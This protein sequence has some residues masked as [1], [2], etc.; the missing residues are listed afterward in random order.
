[1]ATRYPPA[2]IDAALALHDNRLP[3]AER[4]LKD[5]LKR[6]PFEPRAIRMLAELAGRIGRNRDAETLLRRALE[7]APAFTAARANL[8]IV[9]YRLNRPVE[10]L[11][12]LDALLAAEPDHVGH[13]NLKAAALGRLGSFADAIPLY[14]NVLRQAPNQPKVWMSYGHMLKTVGRQQDGVEAYRRAIALKPELGEAWWSLANLKTVRFDD[15]DVAAM[16]A[17]LDWVGLTDEDR[18][19]LDF[20]LGKA[21]EE[22]RDADR[23][24]EHY[25]RGNALRRTQIVY[26]ADETERFVDDVA[27]VATR[28]FFA[29]RAGWGCP[30]REVIFVLGMPR[31]GSTLI[32]QILASHSQIEGTTE[33]PDLP[34]LARRIADYPAGLATLTAD[35]A[36]AMGE[37]Y[38]RRTA[39]QRRTDRPLFIDKLPNNWAHVALIRLI[40]PNAIVIDARREPRACCFSNYKQHFAR[41]QAFSYSLDDMGRYY[42]DY[43]RAMAHVDAVLPGWAH[44]VIHEALVEDTEAEVRR[45][46]AACGVA[47][48]PACLAF[49]DT[50]RAVRTASSE[51][52]RQPIYR[53]GNDAWVPFASRLGTLETA[54]GAVVGAYPDAPK[55]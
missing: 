35:E 39:V 2:L 17:A 24:F 21:W 13:A 53:T 32:E 26:D 15:G 45:M 3:E 55:A 42:R 11:D 41:G 14:E 46:L 37:D 4:G 28:E 44:R 16:Q 50:E 10:A 12:E 19:H 54:L 47:F 27:A 18:L 48:E 5:Y 7:I 29:A 34:A 43:V 40:L 25:A 52:V 6:D 23:A 36:R 33:L 9:L 30:S 49:H 31:A 20:A 38:L 22:R 51:Q 1:M 8:A